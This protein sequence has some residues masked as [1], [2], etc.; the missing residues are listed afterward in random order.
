MTPGD[1]AG[2][3]WRAFLRRFVPDKA[4]TSDDEARRWESRREAMGPDWAERGH[5][6]AR[7]VR[8]GAYAVHVTGNYLA[9]ASLLA[10]LAAA[11][12]ALV[13]NPLDIDSDFV[14]AHGIGAG[15]LAVAAALT[16]FE[17]KGPTRPVVQALAVGA[18]IYGLRDQPDVGVA[19]LQA[20]L[21]LLFW[22]NGGRTVTAQIVEAT[23]SGEPGA[24]VEPRPLDQLAYYRPERLLAVAAAVAVVALGGSALYLRGDPFWFAVAQEAFVAVWCFFGVVA[25]LSYV[26]L[27]MRVWVRWTDRLGR[28]ASE[29]L[30]PGAPP[31]TRKD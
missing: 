18:V 30:K 2:D 4:P 22:S 28:R 25:V 15:V 6:S 21:M 12:W 29:L 31:Y 3:A 23:A 1:V 16:G 17:A 7:A 11:A 10:V 5:R 27:R 26:A 14:Q 9:A 20:G 8:A 13:R 19:V 24:V